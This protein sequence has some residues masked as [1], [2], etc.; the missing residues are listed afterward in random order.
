LV[1]RLLLTSWLSLVVQV[2]QYEVAQVV[3]DSVH[4]LVLAV[5][6]QRQN[7]NYPS[8]LEHPIR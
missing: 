7:Q 8:H 3:V 5:A 1:G 4:R 2:G 6:V